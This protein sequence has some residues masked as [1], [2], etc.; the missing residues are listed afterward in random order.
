MQ[1]LSSYEIDM[2]IGVQI[3]DEAVSHRV[4]AVKKDMIPSLLLTAT[5]WDL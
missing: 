5:D 3:L 2:G 4:N 1:C